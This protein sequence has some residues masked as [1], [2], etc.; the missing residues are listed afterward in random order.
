MV[1]SDDDNGDIIR[2]QSDIDPLTS[3]A[4]EESIEFNGDRVVNKCID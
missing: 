1:D 4:G 2:W 3:I